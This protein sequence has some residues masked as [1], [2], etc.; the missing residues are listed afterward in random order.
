MDSHIT[1]KSPKGDFGGFEC[2]YNMKTGM[3]YGASKTIF[4]FAKALRKNM[5][6]PEKVIWERICNNQLGVKIRRQHPIHNYIVDY[7]CHEVKLVIEVDGG[8]HL[9]KENM[10]NDL[11]REAGLKEYGIEIIRF[12]NE[13]VSNEIDIV[14]EKLSKKIEELK[15]PKSPLGDLGVW[16]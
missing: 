4:Q 9:S 14:I 13:E 12:T 1:P 8:I 16:V 11:I 7:Y 2:C 10:Q 3:H 6:A 15:K 5:T